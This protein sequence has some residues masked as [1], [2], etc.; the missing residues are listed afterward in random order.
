[1]FCIL[2]AFYIHLRKITEPEVI[3]EPD[4]ESPVLVEFDVL[5]ESG[6]EVIAKLERVPEPEAESEVKKLDKEVKELLIGTLVNLPAEFTI[7]LL[8]FF[9]A[10]RIP[11]TLRSPDLYDPLHIFLHETESQG[12]RL[13]RV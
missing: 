8:P 9:S 7:E 4:P 10:M 11:M 3:D 12:I 13:F 1:V 6:P 2:H 5:E